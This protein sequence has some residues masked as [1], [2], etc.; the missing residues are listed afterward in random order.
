M[1]K[2]KNLSLQLLRLCRSASHRCHAEQSE[3]SRIFRLLQRRDSSALPQNDIMIS[4]LPRRF[5]SAGDNS[6]LK[7]SDYDP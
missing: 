6:S 3:A 4:L 2:I 1:L 5:E 7:N